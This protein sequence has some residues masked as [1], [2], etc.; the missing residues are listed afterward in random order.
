MVAGGL[1]VGVC[2]AL[3]GFLAAGISENTELV[4]F[5]KHVW[6]ELR[7]V[8]A[9]APAVVELFAF[10]TGMG[11]HGALLAVG[12]VMGF[13]LVLR[14]SWLLLCIWVITL[15]T[16]AGLNHLLKEIF[17]RTRPDLAT[18]A[19]YSFPSGHSMNSAIT[20]GMLIY[21][22]FL[23]AER[24]WQRRLGVSCMV[25]LVLAIGF[26]RMVLGQHY[27]SDV[28]GGFAAG[29]AVVALAVMVA[30]RLRFHPMPA[31]APEQ[32]AETV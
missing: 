12:V 10:I 1:A 6:S 20:Y 5:D 15:A 30:E 3:F 25:L 27:F 32:V 23:W 22:L 16:G 24:G 7:Q 9:A 17:V 2:L 14:R 29:T 13:Y 11:S 28:L 26:S 21:L 31:T 4:A 18:A 19:G 8:D